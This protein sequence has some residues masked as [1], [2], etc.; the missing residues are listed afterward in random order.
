MREPYGVYDI[1]L[2][3]VKVCDVTFYDSRN[4]ERAPGRARGRS[5]RFEFLSAELSHES[6]EPYLVSG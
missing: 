1:T 3:S 4:P 5:F 6:G 2:R